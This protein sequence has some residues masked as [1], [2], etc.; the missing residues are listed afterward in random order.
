MELLEKPRRESDPME[1]IRKSAKRAAEA[2]AKVAE[3]MKTVAK[4]AE[5][6]S[7]QDLHKNKNARDQQQQSLQ[8]FERDARR[9]QIIGQRAW[10]MLWKTQPNA[11]KQR[12][13][14]NRRLRS[15]AER[16]AK[17]LRQIAEKS[18]A[19][20][21]TPAAIAERADQIKTLK[22]K[23][24]DAERAMKAAQETERF[25]NQRIEQG[26]AERKKL[27]RQ[28]IDPLGKPNPAAELTERMATRATEELNEIKAQL[29]NAAAEMTASD[30]LVADPRQMDALSQQQSRISDDVQ[31][32]ANDLRRVARHQQRLG[33]SSEAAKTSQIANEIEQEAKVA[34][35]NA[36][37]DLQDAAKSPERTP[38][39]NRQITTAE[40][41]IRDVGQRLSGDLNSDTKGENKRDD[42]SQ[43]SR[44]SDRQLAQTLDELDRSISQS[45]N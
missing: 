22:E 31:R 16:Q 35:E 8:R 44:R 37:A 36:E 39:A 41:A 19:D 42:A 32:A 1:S 40:Q 43:Q 29:N 23:A 3:I 33:E 11:A 2:I 15:E 25:A 4:T 34:S 21:Q 9:R 6:A 14:Q 24:A 13:N 17:R 18:D 26:I 38:Q 5:E 28:V 7:E 30:D 10:E 45:Q 12:A 20:S 27:E